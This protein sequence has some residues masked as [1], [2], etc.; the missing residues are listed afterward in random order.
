MAGA[1]RAP[2]SP[3]TYAPGHVDDDVG[4]GVRA[5]AQAAVA[6]ERDR[7]RRAPR[8]AGGVV[9]VRRQRGRACRTGRRSG[10]RRPPG[11]ST[12][13]FT[14]AA[15]AP[16]GT[17]AGQADGPLLAAA[18]RPAPVRV[19][20][21]RVVGTGTN[22]AGAPTG[23]TTA[24]GTGVR[25]AAWSGRVRRHQ[26]LAA[27]PV[28]GRRQVH[29]VAAPPARVLVGLGLPLDDVERRVAGRHVAQGLVPVGL[30]H[31]VLRAGWWP[32][33]RRGRGRSRASISSMS[34]SDAATDEPTKPTSSAP[35]PMIHTG[36]S[37]PAARHWPQHG[38]RAE[39]VVGRNPRCRCRPSSGTGPSRRRPGPTR[40]TDRRPSAPSPR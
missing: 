23:V 26:R 3:G 16:A 2:P 39:R 6:V 31:L 17:S 9:Q 7:R 28:A 35:T 30:P 12:V 22:V 36:G 29:A 14:T 8:P 27:G 20:S 19:S 34:A 32:S 25:A 18:S 21:T 15:V 40:S 37:K 38:R 11:P 1:K 33:P 24:A 10:S 5:Q 4:R 13:R